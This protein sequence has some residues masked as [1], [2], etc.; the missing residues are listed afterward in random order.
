MLN[1]VLRFD[2]PPNEPIREYRPGAAETGSLKEKLDEMAG[3]VREIPCIVGGEEIFTGETGKSGL[4]TTTR[5]CSPGSITPVA[6]W[7]KKR[8]R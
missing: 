4:R 7:W 1:T 6:N 3:E 5:F 8:S 2:S